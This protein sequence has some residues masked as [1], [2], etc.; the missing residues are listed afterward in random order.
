MAALADVAPCGADLIGP[1]FFPRLRRGLHD[2]ARFAGFSSAVSFKLALMGIL[3]ALTGAG[4][5]RASGQDARATDVLRQSLCQPVEPF[6]DRTCA[7]VK[8]GYERW[9][10]TYDGDPNPILALEERHLKPM[11]PPLKGK[12][13]LDL[14]C[15]TGRWLTWLMAAGAGSGVG[16]DSSLAM[17]DVAKLKPN[18]QRRLV[19]ADCG[20]IPFAT[21]AFDLV[22][23]SF[24]VSHIFDLQGM[25]C[26]VGRVATARADIFVSDLHPYAYGHGWHTGFRDSLGAVQIATVSRSEKEFLAPWVSIGFDCVASVTCRFSEPERRVFVHAG[27]AGDFDE[28]CQVPAVLLCHF[29]RSNP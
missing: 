17:L 23:C 28:F 24:A 15:G 20:E 7:S 29:R 9:A 11:L 3:P 18:A 21:G 14:A 5:S 10:R 16:I 27:K 8:K 22:V 12:R 6:M 1:A 19:Q 2:F 25:V 13:V 4:R 26:E